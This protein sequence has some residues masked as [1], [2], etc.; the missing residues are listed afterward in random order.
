MTSETATTMT[1]TDHM[2]RKGT[3]VMKMTMKQERK[4]KTTPSVLLR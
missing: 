1:S 2:P 4:V 3:F